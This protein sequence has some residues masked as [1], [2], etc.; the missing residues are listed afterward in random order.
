M[1]TKTF[2][3]LSIILALTTIALPPIMA[4]NSGNLKPQK[5][6]ALMD[7]PITQI[8]QKIYTIYGPFDLPDEANQGFRNNPLIILTNDGVVVCD[9]GGSA[10]AGT[11]VVEKVKTL[12]NK[13]IIAVFISHAH[14]DHWLGNEAIKNAYP[15]AVIYGHPKA[16]AKIDSSNGIQWLEIINK[17]TKNTAKGTRVVSIDKTVNQGD[18]IAIGGMTFRIHHTGTAHT[19]GDIMV[20]IVEENAIFLGDVVRNDF[21]G[22]MEGDS[23]FK[24]NI[25]AIDYVLKALPRFKYYIPAHGQMGDTALLEKYRSYLVTIYDKVKSLYD[26]GLADY[27]M[28]PKVL[29]SMAPFKQWAG[30]D[31]RFGAH[32]SQVYLEVEA[33][34]F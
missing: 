1:K 15:N 21:L 27:E 22:L 26:T 16:K 31:L 23:S 24:G 7:Y 10:A 17:T 20:E 19:E 6:V 33:E 18:V 30:F 8:S 9:P 2:I 5:P 32:I 3:L 13:P 25:A 11:M 29:K 12:T 34:N 14:G 28:K 4:G